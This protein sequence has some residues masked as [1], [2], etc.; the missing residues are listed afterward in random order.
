MYLEQQQGIPQGSVLSAL[1]C[2]LF[3]GQLEHRQLYPRIRTA[4]STDSSTSWSPGTG[5]SRASPDAYSSRPLHLLLRQV[6]DFLFLSTSQAQA[7]AFAETL[8]RG[9]PELGVSVNPAKTVA[10]FRIK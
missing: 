7:A 6:D 10:N 4:G 3:L 1:L 9:F 2:A 8:S 5:E